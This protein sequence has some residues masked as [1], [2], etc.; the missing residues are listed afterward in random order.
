MKSGWLGFCKGGL[1]GFYSSITDAQV[2]V[3]KSRGWLA[4]LEFL[5]LFYPNPKVFVCVR[6]IRSIMVSMEKL[7]QKNAYLHDPANDN[8]GH[9][10]FVTIDQRVDHWMKSVPVGISLGH[11]R[12][13]LN[14]GHA[15]YLHFVIY[16]NL[17][18]NPQ[19]EINKLYDYI[20]EDRFTHNF[21][22]IDQRTIENDAWHGIYG[23][24][25][26]RPII[27]EN[28]PDW[29]AVLGRGLSQQLVA[30]NWWFYSVF[31][32]QSC[33]QFNVA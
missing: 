7:H 4:C 8:P 2:A 10:N 22:N 13:Q 9:I 28:T 31:Y 24:H 25:T 5:K 15:K 11:L 6:D 29:N 27:E 12:D 1:E 17:L 19:E 14:K 23:E 32:P 3:D 33:N 30:N 18:S 20:E 21:D 26:I 16:E